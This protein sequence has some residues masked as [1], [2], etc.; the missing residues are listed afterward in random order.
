MSV[1][2]ATTVTIAMTT[3]VMIPTEY[4]SYHDVFRSDSAAVLPEHTGI[5]DHP[6]DLVDDLRSYPPAL[7]YRSSTRKTVA[8]DCVSEVSIT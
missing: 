1:L 5:N 4:L 3:M 2:I 6:I 8:F 7:R